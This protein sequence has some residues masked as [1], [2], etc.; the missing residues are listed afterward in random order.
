MSV[1]FTV[2]KKSAA[3]VKG[4]DKDLRQP[5]RKSSSSSS[6]KEGSRKVSPP[7]LLPVV[8]FTSQALSQAILNSKPSDDTVVWTPEIGG[9]HQSIALR[10]SSMDLWFEDE[11]LEYV[12][13]MEDTVSQLSFSLHGKEAVIM[14]HQKPQSNQSS[15]ELHIEGVYIPPCEPHL[16]S[17]K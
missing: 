9:K 4:K 12:T 14:H 17:E 3:L 1:V 6:G 2:G 16:E 5:L 8:Q 7:I 15:F 13:T 11:R 10:R